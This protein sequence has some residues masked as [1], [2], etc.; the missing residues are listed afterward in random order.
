[1]SPEK[2][3][4]LASS[5]LLNREFRE[6]L[7]HQLSS[8]APTEIPLPLCHALLERLQSSEHLGELCRVC[9]IA[10]ED[11]G[12]HGW[13]CFSLGQEGGNVLFF[14][15]PYFSRHDNDEGGDV[16]QESPV[17]FVFPLILLHCSQELLIDPDP[18]QPAPSVLQPDTYQ[19]L[20]L[21]T[22]EPTS[23]PAHLPPDVSKVV[24]ELS[25]LHLS[26]YLHTIH[27]VLLRGLPVQPKDF[28][29]ALAVCEKT[30]HSVNCTPLVAA[31]CQHTVVRTHHGEGEGSTS[32]LPTDLLCQLHSAASSKQ[33][34]SC[35][36]S[37]RSEEP[38]SSSTP[39]C[40]DWS[41]EIEETFQG[42]LA[43]LGFLQVPE[44]AGYYWLS[45]S[46]K[47]EKEEDRSSEVS[48]RTK[49]KP[50]HCSYV[51]NYTVCRQGV[52]I[53]YTA[54]VTAKTGVKKWSRGQAVFLVSVKR[55]KTSFKLS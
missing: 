17:A 9:G 40:E 10:K 36:L 24:S 53:S 32:P 47:E 43:G 4:D 35:R 44:C 29:A 26:S 11:S 28:I 21:S 22:T 50:S 7:I 15:P 30:V 31:L 8:L 51:K 5:S 20:P 6:H 23:L 37:P 49:C 12:A 19:H 55:S 42:Y 48:K 39:W 13:R 46:P 16:T 33:P 27:S 45:S 54:V 41:G 14:L 38:A 52:V 1:M 25:T 18:V 2:R 3:L 34:S